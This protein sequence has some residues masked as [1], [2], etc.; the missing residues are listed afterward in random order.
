MQIVCKFMQIL[1]YFARIVF[2]DGKILNIL[3]GFIFAVA[4]IC[5]V[6]RLIW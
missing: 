1:P 2:E 3:R 4:K 5:N 6:L